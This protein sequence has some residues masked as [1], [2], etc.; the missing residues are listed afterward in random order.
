MAQTRCS[1]LY[2]LNHKYVTNMFKMTMKSN[3][4]WVL[5]PCNPVDV[6][7]RFRS[8]SVFRMEE[9][10]KRG[11]HLLLRAGIGALGETIRTI[12]SCKWKQYVSPIIQLISTRLYSVTS[13]STLLVVITLRTLLSAGRLLCFLRYGRLLGL[14]LP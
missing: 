6:F 12:R 8:A 14:L 13:I 3:I 10:K 11:K 2:R 4:F 1:Q 5:T 7:G 9:Q